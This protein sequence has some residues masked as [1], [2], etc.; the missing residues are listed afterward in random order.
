MRVAGENH[1]PCRKAV[2]LGRVLHVIMM[3]VVGCSVL[4]VLATFI[5]GVFS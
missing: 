5:I 2:Q 4:E 3:L 1:Y